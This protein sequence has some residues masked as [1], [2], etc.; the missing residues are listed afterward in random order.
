[1]SSKSH[2]RKTARRVS[3]RFKV[4]Y[5]ALNETMRNPNSAP[6]R[7][8]NQR[9]ARRDPLTN[10]D[11]WPMLRKPPNAEAIKK[12]KTFRGSA[13][14]VLREFEDNFIGHVLAYVPYECVEDHQLTLENKMEADPLGLKPIPQT[15]ADFWRTRRVGVPVGT[16]PVVT[17]H[18]ATVSSSDSSDGDDAS[19]SSPWPTESEDEGDGKASASKS[20]PTAKPSGEEEKTSK[21]VVKK[22]KKARKK[23]KKKKKAKKSKKKAP[24]GGATAAAAAVAAKGGATPALAGVAPVPASKPSL[25]KAVTKTTVLARTPLYNTLLNLNDQYYKYIRAS[26]FRY[27]DKPAKEYLENIIDAEEERRG[28]PFEQR[29][30]PDKR[31]PWKWIK[32][33]IL[34]TI[35]M[36]TLGDYYFRSL[37]EMHRAESETRSNWC[38]RVTAVHKKIQEYGHGWDNLGCRSA[39]FRLWIFLS[40]NEQ[41]VVWEHYRDRKEAIGVQKHL[42]KDALK[43]DEDLKDLIKVI[44]VTITDDRWKEED[45]HPDLCPLGNS[46]RMYSNQAYLKIMGELEAARAV[47]LKRE[48]I[49]RELKKDLK[50]RSKRK[51]KA[52]RREQARQRERADQTS[53][54]NEGMEAVSQ[55]QAPTDPRLKNLPKTKKDGC[56]KSCLRKGLGFVKH[57]VCDK[58]KQMD[59]IKAMKAEKNKPPSHWAAIALNAR[60]KR[61]YDLDEYNE[62]HC[63]M[64]MAFDIAPEHARRHSGHTCLFRKDGPVQKHL[65]VDFMRMATS[66]GKDRLEKARRA[67]WKAEADKRQKIRDERKAGKK[68]S[69]RVHKS[70]IRVAADGTAANP[71]DSD[72]QP[73]GQ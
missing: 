33:V 30:D 47:A 8:N 6:I 52:E 14:Q 17:A 60:K 11:H 71:E 63:L 20:T 73:A 19:E 13:E 67:V 18:L 55:D 49:I 58:S 36:Q 39:V 29:A 24:D 27:M 21:K 59:K 12:H 40:D 69:A 37:L 9:D 22:A 32:E 5:K 57:A 43:W 7:D 46:Q 50:K 16:V 15:N 65:G 35:C 42:N 34:N 56:C 2:M 51:G 31:L 10:Y 66:T 61:T 23:K 54:G 64:C 41:D 48:K 1:M 62:N 53:D 26:V 68:G 45:F 28:I 3:Q 38:K 44:T 70:N 72:E 4:T 25:S